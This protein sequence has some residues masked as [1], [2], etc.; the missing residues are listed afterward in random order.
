MALFGYIGSPDKR[1]YLKEVYNL[2]ID[3]SYKIFRRFPRPK[4]YL[5]FIV[6]CGIGSMYSY[7]QCSNMDK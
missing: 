6:N 7:I 5:Q 4:I 2:E 3:I 1:T